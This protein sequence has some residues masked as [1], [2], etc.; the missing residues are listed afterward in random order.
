[1]SQDL[2]ARTGPI[3]I[4]DAERDQAV[5]VLSEHFVAGRLTQE[6]FEERSDQA[7]RAR[8]DDDLSPLFTDLPDPAASQPGPGRWPPSFQPGPQRFQPGLP[9]FL[10]LLPVLMV[11]LVVGTVSVA[12]P[13]IL[14]VLFWVAVF[15]RP[16]NHRRWH[17]PHRR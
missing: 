5:A 2:P 9:P 6:E 16:Y 7:T 15:S 14:W 10:W 11:G 12:A 8:Y 4:G 3:R 17:D 1:M 13:W